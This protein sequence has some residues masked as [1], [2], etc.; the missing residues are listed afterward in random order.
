MSNVWHDV[1][2]MLHRFTMSSDI[3]QDEHEFHLVSDDN[4]CICTDNNISD[5]Q[6]VMV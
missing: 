5:Q 6:Y 4:E 2:V 1:L 3:L